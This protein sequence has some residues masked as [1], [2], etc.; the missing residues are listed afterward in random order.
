LTILQIAYTPSTAANKNAEKCEQMASHKHIP[1][2]NIRPTER[3]SKALSSKYADA[4][5]K[6]RNIA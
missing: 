4:M 3:R 5:A 6:A 2:A 1:D